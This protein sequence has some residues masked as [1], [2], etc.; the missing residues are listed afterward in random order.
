MNIIRAGVV[1]FA[2]GLVLPVGYL[3]LGGSTAFFVP[4]WAE[5]LFFPG[6]VTGNLVAERVNDSRVYETVGC[7]T[8]AITYAIIFSLLFAGF[9]RL[10]RRRD[11]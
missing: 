7:L 6:F 9:G 5:I 8:V 1:G 10:S 4:L 2:V 11:S 3:V